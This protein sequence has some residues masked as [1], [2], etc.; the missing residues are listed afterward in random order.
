[1]KLD[2]FIKSPSAAL[3]FVEKGLNVQ[4]VRL[5]LSRLV[6][7]AP[8]AF[9]ESVSL[10]FPR[11]EKKSAQRVFYKAIKKGFSLL[12][13]MAAM[14]ILS[15][16]LVAVFRSQGQAI[17]MANDARLATTASFLAQSKMAEIEREGVNSMSGD[18]GEAFSDYRWEVKTSDDISLKDLEKVELVV[19]WE[20]GALSRSYPIVLYRYKTN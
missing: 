4:E 7:L 9:Y 5:V 13:V 10:L 3:Y 6:R 16:A 20:S 11:S 12:E 8:G 2:G 14:A 19:T 15:I 1:M 17:S 18:F